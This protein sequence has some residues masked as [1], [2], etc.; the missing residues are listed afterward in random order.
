MQIMRCS[1][2]L[3]CRAAV[4]AAGRR[5]C[6]EAAGIGRGGGGAGVEVFEVFH[7]PAPEHDGERSRR[8]ERT[9][10]SYSSSQTRTGAFM[11]KASCS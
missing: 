1:I 11:E 3:R 2:M 9:L 7:N 4:A 8:L 6:V 10:P 5:A